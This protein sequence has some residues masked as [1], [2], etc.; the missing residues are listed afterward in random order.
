[1]LVLFGCIL[2]N[3][4]SFAFILV[5][6][7]TRMAVK[8][9]FQCLGSRQYRSWND[10][11]MDRNV[12]KSHLKLH[13]STRLE[14]DKGNVN[15]DM[16][17][18]LTKAQQ[19]QIHLGEEVF[20][21]Y[22]RFPLDD[23]QLQ[24]G[25]AIRQGMNVIVC[26]PTGAGKTVVGEMALLHSFYLHEENP[27]SELMK[28][29]YTTPL[30]ALSNQKYTDLIP[31][32]GKD[33]VG[34]STGDVSINK[35]NA[36]VTVMTTEV[37]RNMAW[38]RSTSSTSSNVQ[39]DSGELQDTAV[40]VLDEFHYMGYPGRGG[41][42]EESVITSP[43]HIQ[44][45][46]LSATLTNAEALTRWMEHVTGRPTV[47]VEVPGQRRP[48]PLRYLFATRDGLYPLFCDPDAGPGAPKGLLGLRG[49]GG[50]L[51]L[52]EATDR[53]TGSDRRGFGGKANK[54]PEKKQETPMVEKLPRGLLVNPALKAAAEKRMRRVNRALER[55]KFVARGGGRGSYSNDNFDDEW[56][57][58]K[59]TRR[60]QHSLQRKLSPREERKERERLLKKEMRRAVP[61]LSAV[62][63]RLQQK[64]LLPAIFFIF[65]RAGCDEAARTLFQSMKGPRDPNSLSGGE[66]EELVSSERQGASINEVK[67]K[68]RQRGRFRGD[69]I[70]DNNGR[71]F[72]PRNNYISEEVLSSLFEEDDI[73]D[74][75]VLDDDGSPMTPD[76]LNF[77]ATAGLL[78][79]GEV[80]TV[81]AKV[82][83]FNEEN[84][85]IAFD[86]DISE[87]YL[88]GVGSH[89][90]GMLP[91]HK[92]FVEALYQRQLMKI[93]F[94]TETLAAGINMPARTTV[95]CALAKRGDGS[96]MNL[97]E[98]SNLLQMAGRAGRRGMD[99]EGTCVIVATPF[100]SE[101]EAA[102]IL[103]D[104]VKPI[105]SQFS[106]S[107]SLAVNLIER[108]EGK[109]DVAKQLVGNSFAM[110][111]KRKA[112]AV[113]EQAVS[114]G[115]EG[116]AEVLEV[117]AQEHFMNTLVDV[118]Q[119]QVDRRRAKFDIAR[120]ESLIEVLSDRES[121]KKS[122]KSYIGAKKM[123]ELEETTLMYL[124]T[125]L[126]Y[127]REQCS[128][129][130]REILGD[131]LSEDEEDI[132]YQI[133]TQRKRTVTT[134]KEVR[135][136]PFTSIAQIA[137]EIMEEETPEGQVLANTLRQARKTEEPPESFALTADELSVFSKSA[138]VARR[139][140]R[141]LNSSTSGL[142]VA[143][144]L[145]QASEAQAGRDDSWSDMLAITK[146]MVAY[147]CLVSDRDYADLSDLENQVFQL[148][149][150]GVNIGMLAFENSLWCLVA[151]GG[152]WDV[153]GA[154]SKL[155]DFRSAMN[156][157]DNE[158][159]YEDE[160]SLRSQSIDGNKAE[161]EAQN[162]VH[163]LSSMSPSEVAG[164]VSCLVPD[165]GKG[166]GVSVVEQ[167]QRLTAKQQKVVQSALLAMERLSEVQKANGV[168]EGTRSCT[169]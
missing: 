108:G 72:R 155:D 81:Q 28:G 73:N 21:Q 12:A 77:Y 117:T 101:D 9:A 91:A 119:S 136:H 35:K 110:W 7:R 16:G 49:D 11:T 42:W 84:P 106:P 143:E 6:T 64:E 24:A 99:T 57:D 169:L 55:Q 65:S 26:A 138:V 158:D 66:I 162:I 146:T 150:A 50:K 5:D 32:F 46:A 135:R 22:F 151:V 79:L 19:E 78:S 95:I 1:M 127:K 164:F 62:V 34:L 157:F 149:P 86:D 70:E 148:S 159:W 23:W 17:P 85:E 27:E 48:V 52:P 120:L 118:L 112:E 114:A 89:H 20:G 13:A 130:E 113:L 3:E 156:D 153:V 97:L 111:E 137:N 121:L 131:L 47:L 71:T 4:V 98:T 25:G 128:E 2:K 31:M 166:F 10:R 144:L 105:T 134:E 103:T 145:D 140:A 90:A 163:Q 123:L 59:D 142:D 82:L 80:E 88:Y 115:G 30:K 160:S 8:H 126:T 14:Q 139:K 74:V 53:G 63:R 102:K 38:R 94:A 129:E 45:V 60:K 87:Q 37:Y 132:I 168:E 68:T 100:E 83:A 107:Y 122:S 43:K 93:V 92:S 41:V 75:D 165:G 51:S 15:N 167:F 124:E 18:E 40:V 154:S 36:R 109:L 33:S 161:E 125:E 116:V 152:A 61:S 147:G 133:E 69:L 29:I 44:I 141:K 96:S 67:R 58:A 76:D 39:S 104:P 54:G 56:G